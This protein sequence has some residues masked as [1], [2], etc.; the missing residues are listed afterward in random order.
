MVVGYKHRFTVVFFMILRIFLV[1][2]LLALTSLGQT[3]QVTQGF[4]DDANKSFQETRSLRTALDASEA[5]SKAKDESLKAKDET[6]A[7]K[8]DL[9]KIK[10]DKIELLNGTIEDYRKIKCDKTSFLFGLI[11][12]TRCH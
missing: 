12:N 8:N 3:V 7:A 5:A 6:I 2:S 1:M 10:D 11:K 9:L 4:V